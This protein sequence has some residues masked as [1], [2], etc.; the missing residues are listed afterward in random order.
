VAGRGAPTH[1]DLR[2]RWAELKASVPRRRS[3]AQPQREFDRHRLDSLTDGVPRHDR[4]PAAPSAAELRREWER[5]R[6]E[7][8]TDDLPTPAPEPV[9]VV[10][11]DTE[12]REQA[13]ALGLPVPLP[14]KGTRERFRDDMF[15]LLMGR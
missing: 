1:D 7:L 2:H 13:K 5:L 11:T 3:V 4:A 14:R 9:P 10:P 6:L 8:L 15:D 12:L